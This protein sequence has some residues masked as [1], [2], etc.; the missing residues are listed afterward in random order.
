MRRDGHN[1]SI[2]SVRINGRAVE[3]E[4]ARAI[5]GDVPL[6]RSISRASEIRFTID[7]RNRKLIN[8][9]IFREAS[10]VEIGDVRYRLCKIRKVGRDLQLTAEDAIAYRMRK[11]FGP[12]K[13]FRDEMTRAQFVISL[14]REAVPNVRIFSPERDTVQPIGAPED[15]RPRTAKD[16]REEGREQPE[17]GGIDRG[18]NLTVKGARATP[19]QIAIGNQV[20]D[21]AMRF[22]PPHK[23]LVALISA[24]IVESVM[25]TRG[26]TSPVDLDSIG[27]LQGR[28]K[29]NDRNDLMDIEYNVRRFMFRPWTG[30]SDGGA[31]KQALEQTG[32]SAGQIAQSIQGSAY[33]ERYD[34]HADEARA[35]ID[36]YGGGAGTGRGG[37]GM[38]AAGRVQRYAYEV[39]ADENYW[40]ASGRLLEEVGWR[41]FALRNRLWI[42]S[43]AGLYTGRAR[44]NIGERLPVGV[45]EVDF[46]VDAGKRTDQIRIDARADTWQAGPGTPLLLS[47]HWGAAAGRYLVHDADGFVNREDVR[48]T[49][50]RPQRPLP[51]PV[52][53]R[54]VRIGGADGG[55]AFGG[56][57]PVGAI[58]RVRI[59]S[60]AP[61]EPHW[62]GAFHLFDQFIT[63]FLNG[64]YGLPVTSTKRSNDSGTGNSDHWVGNTIAYATDYG[65]YSGDGPSRALAAAMGQPGW[66]PGGYDRFDVIVDGHRFSVQILW[67][68][69]ADH[70]NHIHVGARIVR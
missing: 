26:M 25:G 14:A 34:Q 47:E 53:R 19:Q 44:M 22:N 23:A 54:E 69:D 5:I 21:I 31:I 70:Y 32:K 55:G 36:A 27:L 33:P 7:H 3:A 1:A 64:K 10:L 59:P 63:P 46:D 62:G 2:E 11:V 37:A 38:G 16:R 67:A 15:E 9:P 58:A 45:N 49:A 17:R 18:A 28:Q 20:L 40:D 43:D 13:A 29:Y 56:G 60:T 48:I 41:R 51:E 39:D 61:G 6:R 57:E 50:L 12:K 65:T 35:W 4:I 68:S 24:C 42:A 52:A 30:T 66:T 8:H